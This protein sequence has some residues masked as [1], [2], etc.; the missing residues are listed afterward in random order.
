MRGLLRRLQGALREMQAARSERGPY[1]YVVRDWA[2]LSDV[3]VAAA[4]LGTDF[5]REEVEPVELQLERLAKILV[6]APHQDDETIGAG[7]MLLKAA[8]RSAAIDLVYVTD[9]AIANPPYAASTEA[10]VGVRMAEARRVAERLGA[11]VFELGV[12]NVAPR[13]TIADVERLAEL[14]WQS[15]PEVILSPW[16]LDWPQKHRVVNHLLWLAHLRRPLPDVEIWGYQVH[17]QLLANAYVDI[18]SVIDAKREL[19]EM[20][21]SQNSSFHDYAHMTLGM[22]AWNSRLVGGTGR[23][24]IET[25]F[26]LPMREFAALA[27]H[28]YTRDL[29]KLYRGK[30]ALAAAMG[31]L[32]DVVMTER[33]A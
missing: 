31:A 26:T 30:T 33:S 16:L 2:R 23:R 18:T 29:D 5:F 9:G 8:A 14:I 13:P 21:V 27:G 28:F 12:S 22:N 17:N 3:N 19:L 1:R 32:H 7:G 15:R 24:F 11:R 20:F 6:L 25:F 10:G 4:V